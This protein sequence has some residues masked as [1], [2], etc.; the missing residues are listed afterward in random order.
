MFFEAD[1]SMSGTIYRSDF[2]RVYE[3]EKYAEKMKKFGFTVLQ[4]KALFDRFEAEGE[5][6]VS[7]A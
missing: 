1:A 3:K 2:L 5:T 4:I 7:L 6:K